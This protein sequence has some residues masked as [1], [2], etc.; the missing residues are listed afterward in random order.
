[1]STPVRFGRYLLL[2]SLGSGGMA[3]VWRARVEGTGGFARDVVIK[4]IRPGFLGAQD[5]L[6]LFER[7]A[8]LSA[9]L[10]HANIVQ[11]FDYGEVEHEPYLAMEYVEGVAVNKLMARK[12]PLAPGLAAYIARE[13]GRALQAVHEA[14]D[15]AGQPLGLVHRDV[16]PSN[17][18]LGADGAV[19]LLDF[20]VAKT[21]GDALTGEGM[22]R[23]KV[24]Y[25][26]PE[27][28]EG[29]P[30]DARSDL[31]A[32]GVMLHEMLTGRRLFAAESDART[33][34]LVHTAEVPLLSTL[35]PEVPA[36]LESVCHRL[37]ARLPGDRFGSARELVEAIDPLVFELKTGPAQ[38]AAVVAPFV[39]AVKSARPSPAPAQLSPTMTVATPS[40]AT[41]VPVRSS[42]KRWVAP[43]VGV[44]VL[45]FALW[46]KPKVEPP[47]PVVE[48][49][50]P[51][52]KAE[53]APPTPPPAPPVD[54]ELEIVTTPAG[55]L[56][57]TGE[58]K[59]LGTTPLRAHWPANA[60]PTS[61][62]FE[63]KG[64]HPMAVPLPASATSLKLSLKPA[65]GTASAAPDIAGGQ[66]VD[67]FK[68]E[69]KESPARRRNAR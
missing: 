25:A 26:A 28:V 3:E 35:V 6:K 1:M 62:S 40:A 46:P 18:M 68:Q 39:E 10:H 5:F 24:G 59:V 55:A 13:I 43:A 52:K 32:L 16:T 4:R 7:E 56:V 53:L 34:H 19:K 42:S 30:H 2:E 29:S 21:S 61:L 60:R 37:L 65:K 22:L 51:E 27:V 66:V 15:D 31:F 48:T 11:V 23:G 36:A 38:L 9:R 8:R 33:L 45:A 44:A 63:R 64:F 49:P 54:E 20:G 69:T 12:Q 41:D 50:P 47:T 57:K 67:P 58:G 17:V 14:R